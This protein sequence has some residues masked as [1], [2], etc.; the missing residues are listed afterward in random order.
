M[1]QRSA[2]FVEWRTF[3]GNNDKARKL[4]MSSATSVIYYIHIHIYWICWIQEQ[5]EN[6]TNEKNFIAVN[7]IVHPSDWLSFCL[8]ERNFHLRRQIGVFGCQG[9]TGP[10]F[11]CHPHSHSKICEIFPR[12]C[13]IF[14]SVFPSV[15]K[16]FRIWMNLLSHFR[17]IYQLPRD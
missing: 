17:C 11:N 13:W 12:Q 2:T 10:K 5:K 16:L 1:D 9:T 7:L 8:S 3:W 4:A 14:K 6:D 15:E